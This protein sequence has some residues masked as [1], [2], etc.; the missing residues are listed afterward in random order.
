[1]TP[2]REKFYQKRMEENSIVFSYNDVRELTQCETH[3][4]K[5][6]FEGPWFYCPFCGTTKVRCNCGV[7]N[8]Q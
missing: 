4:W 1:M 7:E 2:M 6:Y 8:I 5:F 3:G